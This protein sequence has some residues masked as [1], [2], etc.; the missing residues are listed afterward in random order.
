M[1]ACYLP[2]KAHANLEKECMR[3]RR[4]YAVTAQAALLTREQF[5]EGVPAA[6][7]SSTPARNL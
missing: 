5:I 7:P 1:Q 4:F 3:V 6:T 2:V